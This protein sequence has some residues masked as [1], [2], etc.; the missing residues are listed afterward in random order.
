MLCLLTGIILLLMGLT[1]CMTRNRGLRYE[2][3]AKMMNMFNYMESVLVKNQTTNL[4]D[5]EQNTQNRTQ[6]CSLISG[7]EGAGEMYK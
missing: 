3:L 4:V 5:V 6:D 2:I 7:D 1:A